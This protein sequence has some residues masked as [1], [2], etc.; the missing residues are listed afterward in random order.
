M[1]S[2]YRRKLHARN[3]TITDPIIVNTGLIDAIR[4][5]VETGS[6]EVSCLAAKFFDAFMHHAPFVESYEVDNFVLRNG[7]SLCIW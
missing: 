1:P 6:D 7:S 3:N 2:A 5:Y 4:S